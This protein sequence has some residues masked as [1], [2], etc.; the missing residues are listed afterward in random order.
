MAVVTICSDSEAQENKVCHHFHWLKPRE[1]S[2]LVMIVEHITDQYETRTKAPWFSDHSSIYLVYSLILGWPLEHLFSESRWLPRPEY[3]ALA[4]CRIR[5]RWL[6]FSHQ[7]DW[8]FQT[9]SFLQCENNTKIRIA[10]ISWVLPL[11]QIIC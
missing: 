7:L 11:Y 6:L 1:G 9:L 5:I 8:T 3:W 2:D 4:G 10:S